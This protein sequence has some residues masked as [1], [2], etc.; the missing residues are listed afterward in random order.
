MSVLEQLYTQ[1]QK[2]EAI[3][4]EFYQRA[5]VAMTQ[6]DIRLIKDGALLGLH[7]VAALREEN[8]DA[9]VKQCLFL[10]DRLDSRLWFALAASRLIN[11]VEPPLVV[12][13][14]AGSL[15]TLD[16]RKVSLARNEAHDIRAT[17]RDWRDC[18]RNTGVFVIGDLRVVK[19]LRCETHCVEPTFRGS[20]SSGRGL[21][22]AWF[23]SIFLRSVLLLPCS[24]CI[25]SGL[26]TEVSR[27]AEPA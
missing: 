19:N 13:E 24:C 7:N 6:K 8:L 17:L 15:T 18:E 9:A 14:D 11:G 26:A 5:G 2:N 3:F 1:S 10:L 27:S 12:R 16:G 21:S 23:F 22:K 20:F 4:L 25:V